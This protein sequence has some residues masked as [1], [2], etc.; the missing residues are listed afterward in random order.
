MLIL[1]YLF[2]DIILYTDLS[3]IFLILPLFK[4]YLTIFTYKIQL[5]KKQS[6]N[7]NFCI[8]S[9]FDFISILQNYPM[10]IIILYIR[11][12]LS[13]KYNR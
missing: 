2:R 8:S 6:P 5:L 4:K 3:R 10:N 12:Y 13:V 11:H 7:G 1:N 9:Y